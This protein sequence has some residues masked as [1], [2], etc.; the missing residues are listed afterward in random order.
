MYGKSKHILCSITFFLENRAFYEITWTSI[1]EP[2]IPQIKIWRIRIACWIPKATHTHTHSVYVTLIFFSTASMIARTRL[3]AM[4]YV[5]CLSCISRCDF[6]ADNISATFWRPLPGKGHT[7][8]HTHTHTNKYTQRG[9][10]YFQNFFQETYVSSVN[11]MIIVVWNMLFSESLMTLVY[12]AYYNNTTTSVWRTNFPSRMAPL[13]V[14]SV[15][16]SARMYTW[17]ISNLILRSIK[18]VY[19]I[20]SLVKFGQK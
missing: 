5:H 16:P 9:L 7:H 4:F 13:T 18:N 2:D 11:D 15:C 17:N 6:N 1:V 19:W 12:E 3:N 10:L 14:V 8:T 20:K